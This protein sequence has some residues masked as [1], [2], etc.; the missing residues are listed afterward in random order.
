[1]VANY[2]MFFVGLAYIYGRDLPIRLRGPEWRYLIPD[3][4][5]LRVVFVKGLPMGLQMLLFTFSALV[6]IGLVNRAGVDVTA[7]YGIANQLWT[8]IQMPAVAVSTAVSAMVAQNIGANKWDRVS[9]TTLSGIAINIAITG[10]MV[11]VILLFDRPLFT[12]FVGSDSPAIPIARHI[13][14][15]GS[16]SFIV[17]GIT[18]VIFSTIR[19][20]GGVYMPLL[21]LVCS[22]F[23]GRIGFA[24]LMLPRWG[25]DAL[26]WSFPIG[27]AVSLTMGVTYYRYGG[28][29]G[30]NM[31]TRTVKEEAA[32][33][34]QADCETAGRMNPNG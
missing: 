6:M 25:T 13:Q 3:P 21:I 8:Y 20:N 14:L 15:I 9:A 26:W 22:M 32:E 17:F 28:W 30:A 4:K 7:A 2:I 10:V 34:A 11:G 16:W 29:R 27:S 1:M 33:A 31:L 12:L 24:W 5:L 18:M 19:A 23:V